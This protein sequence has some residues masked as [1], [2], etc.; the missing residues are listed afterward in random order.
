MKSY[1]RPIGAYS[2]EA[3]EITEEVTALLR[4]IIQREHQKGNNLLELSSILT[5]AVERSF[6][7]LP[8]FRRWY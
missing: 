5:E 7:F 4:P 1:L 3:F 8:P 2:K 6:A